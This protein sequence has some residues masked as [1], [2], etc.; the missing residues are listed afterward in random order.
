[1][2]FLSSLYGI[3]L[4]SHR[5]KSFLGF[6]RDFDVDELESRDLA[7]LVTREPG[8]KSFIK[9]AFKVGKSFLGFRRDVDMDEVDARDF[10]DLEEID[11]RDFEGL[12]ELEAREF[13]EDLLEERDPL[14]GLGFRL[15]KG[16][17][18]FAVKG[19]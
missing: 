4:I 19:A 16:A 9:G 13:E 7:E 14:I 2:V 3:V 6:R 8:F 15:A 5:S 18:K 10:E 12:E 1:M 17:A 11:A